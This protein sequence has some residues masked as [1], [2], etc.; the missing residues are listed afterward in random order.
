MIF[1][2]TGKNPDPRW[3][4]RGFL[5]HYRWVARETTTICCACSLERATEKSR[6][7]RDYLQIF[8]RAGRPQFD[9]TGEGTIITTYDKLSKYLSLLTR[10][11]PIESQFV[12]CIV[13]NMNAEVGQHSH[14]SSIRFLLRF[15]SILI[16][17]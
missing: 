8:G 13:D 4:F 1:Y 16:A 3:H 6:D 12:E 17:Y 10:Q 2:P 15:L 7:K 11:D 5:C 14:S 9:T